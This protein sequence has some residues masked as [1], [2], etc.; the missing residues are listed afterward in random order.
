M[1]VFLVCALQVYASKF[2]KR[3]PALKGIDVDVH[4]PKIFDSKN[5]PAETAWGKVP[6]PAF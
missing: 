2:L 4:Q 5:L 3:G 1:I 6:T